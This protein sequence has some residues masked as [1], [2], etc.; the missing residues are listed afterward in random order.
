MGLVAL[1]AVCFSTVLIFTRVIQGLDT[2][3]ITFFRLLFGFL[4]I[5]L[6]LTRQREALHMG[7]Y[8]GDVP[9]LVGLGAA[10]GAA[11]TLYT[12]AIQHTTA[13]NAALL[14]NSAPI[15][16]A[17][18]APWLLGEP[19]PRYTWP[20]LALA[21][22]GIVLITNPGEL[23]LGDGSL[24]GIAAGLGAGFCYSLT[25]LI[26]RHLRGR[27]SSITQIG[28]GAGVATLLL[29]PAALRL[30]SG[31]V[32]A[33]L[34]YLI[35][36]GVLTIGVSYLLYFLGLQRTTAQIVSVVALLEPVS[37]VI[38]GLLLFQEALTPLSAVGSACVL[39][40]IAL[41]SR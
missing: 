26:G 14:A 22:G 3:S 30:E 31:P 18:L 9:L 6:L 5:C 33:N 24:G 1:G 34:P 11:A 38:I 28:W 27:V 17:L 20:S 37:G 8:R 23:R 4:F 19:R 29:L 16:V 41:I 39:G 32:L 36:L 21:L 12:H 13:A 2:L 15:Y 25:L 35:P 7:R 40:S 10:M